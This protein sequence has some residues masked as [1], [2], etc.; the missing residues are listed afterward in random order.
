[1]SQLQ[2]CLNLLKTLTTLHL[3]KDNKKRKTR[4]SV[5]LQYF[6]TKETLCCSEKFILIRF[7]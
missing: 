1:M 2:S 6:E 5:I 7:T 3:C 4:L